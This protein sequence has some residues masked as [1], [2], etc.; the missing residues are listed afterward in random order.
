M[1]REIPLGDNAWLPEAM[2]QATQPQVYHV[3]TG[4][5][6]PFQQFQLKSLVLRTLDALTFI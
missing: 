1:L 6:L 3:S 4:Q 5:D 2:Q